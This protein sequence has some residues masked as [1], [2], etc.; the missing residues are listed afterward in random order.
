MSLREAI[1]EAFAGVEGTLTKDEVIARIYESYP[2]KPWKRQ[3]IT[4]HLIGLSV[5]HPTRRHF[6]TLAGQAFLE[7]LGQ[8]RYRVYVPGTEPVPAEEAAKPV[9]TKPAG[10]RVSYGSRPGRAAN[11]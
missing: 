8:D 7:S 11:K 10:S 6:P 9:R 3:T 5:N 4:A 2:E 1:Q